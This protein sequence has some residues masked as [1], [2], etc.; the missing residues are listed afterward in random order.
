[1]AKK[2][3][4]EVIKEMQE[5]QAK[6]QEIQQA[7][8]R[9][10]RNNKPEEIAPKAQPMEKKTEKS[11]EEKIKELEA[12]VRQQK[13]EKKKLEEQA[14]SKKEPLYHKPVEIKKDPDH[15]VKKYEYELSNNHKL[16]FMIKMHAPSISEQA[17]IQQEYTDLTMGRGEGF[18]RQARELFLAIA[19]YRVAGDNVPDWFINVENTYRTDILLDVWVDYQDWLS[20][21]L[22]TRMH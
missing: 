3:K 2:S 16:T 20:A 9:V 1:M 22:D 13:E 19:Y 18:V 21:Y 15:F 5:A 12:K 4:E 7:T 10:G 11:P 6:R 8:G 17:N 14:S